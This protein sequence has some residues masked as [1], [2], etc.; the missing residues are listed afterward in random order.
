MISL[1]FLPDIA[2]IFMLAFGRLGSLCMLMP[3]TGES[4]IPQRVRLSLALLLT[5][6]FY[7]AVAGYYPTGL[8]NN[9]PKLVVYLGAE[10]AVGIFLGLVGRIVLSAGQVA[11]T[12]IAN[13][14]GL[15]FAM[16]VDP[17]QGQQGVIFGNFLSML[18]MTMIFVTDLHHLSV[19]ALGS[20]FTLFRPGEWMP[21]GDFAQVAVKLVADSFRIGLQ[22]SAPF[23]AFG[24]VFNLGLGVLAKL[25]PQLQIF[26]IATPLS[27]GGGMVLF[28][29]LISTIMLWY[30]DHVRDGL[31]QL[32]A[33]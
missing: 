27:I 2:V 18:A 32:V 1:R 20:S 29:L 3:G 31:S 12:I 28:A 8:A 14:L 11:G 13:Q 26:F 10:I 4:G 25:M 6:M 9:V 15:G 22:V 24:L 17:S 7:P 5:L 16:T 33:S 21:V 30:V 19:A 23:L